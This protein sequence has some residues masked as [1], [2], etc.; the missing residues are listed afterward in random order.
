MKTDLEIID[1]VASNRAFDI[2]GLSQE[3]LVF[4]RLCMAKARESEIINFKESINPEEGHNVFSR[5]LFNKEFDK[6]KEKQ[7]KLPNT[8]EIHPDDFMDFC[9]MEVMNGN[10]DP[11]RSLTH[12]RNHFKGMELKLNL[13]TKKGFWKLNK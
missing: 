8:L 1:E 9:D 12:G 6:Y 5:E 7:G 2:K 10:P 13:N 4:V 11:R 3:E